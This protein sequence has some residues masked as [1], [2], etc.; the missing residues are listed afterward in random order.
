MNGRP[1]EF[2]TTEILGKIR[3]GNIGKAWCQYEALQSSSGFEDRLRALY[4]MKIFWLTLW[5]LMMHLSRTQDNPFFLF[6]VL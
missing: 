1:V 3:T 6:Q 2:S 5:L 4:N